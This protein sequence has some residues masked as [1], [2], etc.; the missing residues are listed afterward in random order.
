MIGPFSRHSVFLVIFAFFLPTSN[1]NP[2]QTTLISAILSLIRVI[3]LE[4]AILVG[5]TVP[6]KPRICKDLHLLSP[7][8]I[9]HSP[10]SR[11]ELLSTEATF[12]RSYKEIP[13]EAVILDRHF[14]T[15]A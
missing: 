8:T 6:Q 4:M 1:Q 14:R 12:I 10:S 7:E 15:G 11:A 5:K 9:L 3:A 13:L 2:A